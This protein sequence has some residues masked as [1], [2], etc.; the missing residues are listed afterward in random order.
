METIAARPSVAVL[1]ALRDRV[2]GPVVGPGDEG[3]DRARAAWN[4]AA[5]QRP[6]AVVGA[7][8][9]SD[10][11]ATLLVARAH[12]LGV[13]PQASGHAAGALPDLEG[14]ILLR[15]GA[16]AGVAVDPVSRTAQVRAGTTWQEV[17]AATAPHGLAPLPGSA[18][19]VGVV[20][21]TLGGGL[22]FLGRLHGLATRHVSALEVVLA[23]GRHVRASA[24][25]HPDLYWALLGGGGAFGVVVALELALHPLPQLSA[26]ALFWPL[27]RAREVL[28]AWR[29]WCAEAP[30]EITTSARLLR[31]PPDPAVPEPLRGGAFVVVDGA[32]A[33]PES[34]CAGALRPLRELDPV[35][36]TFRPAEIGELTRLHMDPPHPVPAMLDHTL[37]AGADD[38][39]L[40]D[41]VAAAGAESGTSLVSVELRQLGGAIAR[42]RSEGAIAALEAIEAP[43]CLVAIGIPAGPFTP[44]AVA[45]DLGRVLSAARP[46]AAGTISTFVDRFGGHRAPTPEVGARLRDVK[47]RYDDAGT[48][49]APQP[50]QG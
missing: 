16:L 6:A 13:A 47:A 36:D 21:Y 7:A 26:G 18:G 2:T 9:E 33:G 35:L 1:A 48:I 8:S 37:L 50:P 24:A 23:D 30:E 39:L 49:V 19:D 45:A 32:F 22:S 43:F 42:G 46:Q 12:G 40:D 27:A 34:A 25:E 29:D 4:L 3:Y 38:D 15:T 14:T 28:G 10:V 31:F 17:L 5:D 44:D 20:G 41:L 11:A